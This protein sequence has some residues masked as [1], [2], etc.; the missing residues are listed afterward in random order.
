MPLDKQKY[1]HKIIGIKEKGCMM[2]TRDFPP[3]NHEHSNY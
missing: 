1:F 3:N 2:H